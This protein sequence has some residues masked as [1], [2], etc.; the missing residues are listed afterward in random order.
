MPDRQSVKGR[1]AGKDSVLLRTDA[2]GDWGNLNGNR[3]PE[4]MARS[5]ETEKGKQS[6]PELDG[7]REVAR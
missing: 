5:Q 2:E 6:V 4:T 1:E 3:P 7:L